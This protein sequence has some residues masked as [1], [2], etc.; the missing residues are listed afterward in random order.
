[1]AVW[2]IDSL[3]NTTE[4]DMNHPEELTLADYFA[5]SALNALMELPENEW[6]MYDCDFSKGETTYVEAMAVAAY[7]IADAMMYARSYSGRKTPP[8]A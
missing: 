3:G 5:A 4:K 6:P 1:M 7:G 2:L 8:N